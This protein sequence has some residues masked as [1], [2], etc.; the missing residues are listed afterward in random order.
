MLAALVPDEPEAHA[1]VALMEFQSSRFGARRGVDGA[2][3]MLD[4]QDRTKWDHAQ[5]QRGVTAL[6]RATAL[7]PGL[8]FYGLQ[9]ALAECHATA[10]TPQQTDWD[11]IVALYEALGRLAPSPVVE[12][13][14][15]IAVSM[16]SG[17]A[18]ALSI[19]DN[20]VGLDDSYLRPS[21]RGELLRRLGRFAEAADE[22]E[23]AAAL[24]GNDR[25]RDILVDK[26]FK[27]AFKA[28]QS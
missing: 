3:I 18:A 14:R 22:F 19:L 23:T 26:A 8:G 15:A 24:T 5:I 21:V 12:L 16:T 2:A 13:N 1:L 10:S 6:A 7:S 17:P 11:R 27:A 4:D 9:A 25:E 20:V 28:R